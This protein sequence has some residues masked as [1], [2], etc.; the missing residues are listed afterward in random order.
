MSDHSTSPSLW[1][2]RCCNAI[3]RRAI[4]GGLAPVSAD[5][6]LTG[7]CHGEAISHYDHIHMRHQF[8]DVLV[9]REGEPEHLIFV[10]NVGEQSSCWAANNQEF[11]VQIQRQ[12]QVRLE[13]QEATHKVVPFFSFLSKGVTHPHLCW[14]YLGNLSPNP[15]ISPVN[16]CRARWSFAAYFLLHWRRGKKPKSTHRFVRV[17]VPPLLLLLLLLL[18]LLPAASGHRSDRADEQFSSDTMSAMARRRE[19]R[20]GEE[21][22]HLSL[23]LLMLSC[24]WLLPRTKRRMT[25]ARDT[26]KK[27]ERKK[28]G[29][30]ERKKRKSRLRGKKLLILQSHLAISPPVKLSRSI[31]ARWKEGKKERKSL[32]YVWI[33]VQQALSSLKDV[34]DRVQKRKKK[35]CFTQETKGTISHPILTFREGKWTFSH[36]LHV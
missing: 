4:S 6:L 18:P 14:C 36:S 19:K 9:V 29:K 30:K 24:P 17:C 34:K 16:W 7:I 25:S 35:G 20:S 11:M 2:S 22:R 31:V 1:T 26:L 5:R 3:G 15:G 13:T 8:G 23:S 33:Q 12:R 28:E 27:N 32:A 10:R 21:R